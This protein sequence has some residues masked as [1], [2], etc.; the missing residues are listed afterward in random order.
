MFIQTTGI[1]LK[2]FPYGD[3]SLIA[4]CFSKKR[5]KIS[6]I[7]KGSRSKKSSKAA[8]FEPLSYI[9]F[10]Y[11]YKPNRNLQILSKVSFVEY[12]SNILND[13]H[14]VT[15][16]MAIL[17]ITEKI[18]LDEDPH[19]DLFSVLKDVL[20]SYNEKKHN[21]NLLFW[22]Y[23]CAL[24]IHLG[25]KP[26][27]DVEKLPGLNLPKLEVGT[28]SEA[29]ISNLLSGDIK[30]IDKVS[31]PKRDSRIISDYLWMLLCYHFDNL[32]NVKFKKVIKTILS[33]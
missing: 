30:S 22:Y 33:E 29:I 24:L 13:L 8:H 2:S 6:L 3:T 14:S 23:E 17:D 16:S 19:P 15:L 32:N 4:K 11:N 31:I 27:L 25:L 26:T 21:P 5:G 28:K 12:W 1:I 18:L 10:I 9:N 20:K 7:I